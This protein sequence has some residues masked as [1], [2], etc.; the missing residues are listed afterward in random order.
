MNKRSKAMCEI[1]RLI[2]VER[3]HI[4]DYLFDDQTYYSHI[5]FA[6]GDFIFC[7]TAPHS[8]NGFSYMLRA[9]YAATHDKWGNAAYE[10][11]F[12]HPEDVILKILNINFDEIL[13]RR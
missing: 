5:Y 10:E 7:L 11:F 1:K 3:F 2:E 6:K 9:D 4:T 13:D 12:K 8:G